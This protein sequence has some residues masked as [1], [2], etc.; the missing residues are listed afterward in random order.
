MEKSV[1]DPIWTRITFGETK[2]EFLLSL[3]KT[4]VESSVLEEQTSY[5]GEEEEE[6]IEF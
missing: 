1:K 5:Q 6:S 3:Q 4:Y 2:R